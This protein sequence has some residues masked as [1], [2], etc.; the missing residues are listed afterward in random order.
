ALDDLGVSIHYG[1]R[2][3]GFKEQKVSFLYQD[4]L[5]EVDYHK[6]ILGT[7]GASWSKTGSDGEWTK[8]FQGNDVLINPFQAANSGLESVL[9]FSALAGKV[10][11]NVTLRY[12]NIIKTGEV[13]IT[14]YGI[15]GAPVY[16]MNRYIRDHTFPLYLY[17]DL[18]PSLSLQDIGLLLGKNGKISR[19][20]KNGIKLSDTALSLTKLLPRDIYTDSSKLSY[21][22]KNFPIQ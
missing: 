1:Y 21:A 3:V 15:E 5:S 20:L 6:L 12:E 17:I 11:K 4:N 22:I 13:V 14:S 8:A 9:D 2:M 10:L 19:T 7:G 18:K 16:F